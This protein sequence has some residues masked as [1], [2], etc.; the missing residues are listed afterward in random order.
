MTGT[1]DLPPGAMLDALERG[2]EFYRSSRL[3]PTVVCKMMRALPG[4]YLLI[5]DLLIC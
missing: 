3:L 5:V 4:L 1:E 2:V